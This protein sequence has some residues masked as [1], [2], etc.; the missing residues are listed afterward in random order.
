MSDPK[1][2]VRRLYDDVVNAGNLDLMDELVADDFVEHE[3]LPGMPSDREA[4]RKMF[5]MSRQA[6][7]DFRMQVEDM[8]Q[9]GDKVVARIRMLG[10][11]E[12][13]F[14]GVPASGNQ[15]DVAAIDIMQVRGDQII[16]HW[17]VTDIASMMEQMG[18]GGPAS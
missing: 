15:I 3:A 17:G 16:A 2:V 14:M 7:P 6:F 9:E 18:V 12:G 4:P 1:T 13:E 8:I 5:E 11:H 10:T